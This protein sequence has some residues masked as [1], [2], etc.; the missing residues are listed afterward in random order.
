MPASPS[1]LPDLPCNAILCRYNEIGTKGRN[2]SLFIEQLCL[3][4]RRQ[5]HELGE[6]RLQLQRSRIVLHPP[7]GRDC[8]TPAD[9]EHLR[10]TIPGVA[11]I[12]SVSPGFLVQPDTEAILATL[13]THF[14]TLHQAFRQRRDDSPAT[15]AVRVNKSDPSFPLSSL[16]LELQCAARYLPD[17]PDLR[18]D[19]SHPAFLI[20]IEIRR[21]FA[22]ICCERIQGPGG[23]PSGSSGRVLALLSGGF[24]SP[25]ACYRMMRRG[26]QVDFVTFHSSPYTPPALLTKVAGIVRQLNLYQRR[27]RLAAVNLLPA[28]E[29]IRDLCQGRYRT[30]LYRRLMLRLATVV[31]RNFRDKALVTGDNIGQVASQ[32][33]EN[34]AVINTAS[35]L[36]VLRPL[37][38]C[39]KLEIMN[40]A[41]KI[42]TYE[43]S[44]ENVPDSCTV[45]AG[46]SPATRALLTHILREEA[47]LNIPDLMRACLLQANIINPL[48]DNH[49]PFSERL[50]LL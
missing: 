16:E 41:E 42:G 18:L 9:L 34:L 15:Y 4:L 19:L 33:L 31:A 3:A 29:A 6:L 27:G 36:L 21:P 46:P 44:C 37:L 50:D 1:W 17:R 25:V 40:Q 48:A 23:L 5:L 38:A 26:C 30:I 20:E 8:F 2:R 39:D 10:R 47:R 43:L 11:G 7:D 12:A 35:E 28:Q 32:T 13:D 22:F 14:E 24:D 49:H 45:F